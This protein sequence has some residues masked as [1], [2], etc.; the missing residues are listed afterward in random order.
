MP[1][2]AHLGLTKPLNGSAN[3]GDA[4]NA[5]FDA[6]D[7][8]IDSGVHK[9][10]AAAAAQNYSPATAVNPLTQ[11]A[12]AVI[13]ANH[14]KFSDGTDYW[15]A[16]PAYASSGSFIDDTML[17]MMAH[18]SYFTASQVLNIVQKFMANLNG[19]GEIPAIVGTNGTTPTGG[20]YSAWD[21]HHAFASGDGWIQ[22]PNGLYLYWQKTGDTSPYSTYVAAIKT[23]LARLPR[24]AANHLV[25][26][27]AGNEYVAGME[28]MEYM[29]KTGDDANASVWYAVVCQKL[30]AIATAAG[31]TA[32][33]TFFTTEANN[34]IAGIK[35]TLIDPTSGLLKAAT[36]QCSSNLDV[37][38]SSLACFYELLTPA[39]EL[40]IANYFLTN[41]STLVNASG[42]ILQSPTAWE[43][44]GYIPVG[45][46]A[47]YDASPFTATQ[48]QGGYWSFHFPWFAY[49]LAKVSLSKV[50]ELLNTFLNGADP[51]TEYFNQG[52]ST[53]AGTTPNLESPSGAKL[54]MDLFP[55]LVTYSASSAAVTTYGAGPTGGGSGSYPP[56]GTATSPTF[57]GTVTVGT[58]FMAGPALTGAD[59]GTAHNLVAHWA[60]QVL[61]LCNSDPTGTTA[62]NFRNSDGTDVGGNGLGNASF[63]LTHLRNALYFYANK[64]IL[65]AT[66]GTPN[67]GLVI[68]SANNATFS[69]SLSAAKNAG[70]KVVIGPSGFTHSSGGDGNIVLDNANTDTPG[71]VFQYGN[72]LNYGIDSANS[73]AA[74]GCSGQLL[75]FIKQLDD[76]GG[77]L[78]AVMDASGNMGISGSFQASRFT[79]PATA[80]TGSSGG[81]TGWCFSQDGHIS[82]ADGTNWSLKI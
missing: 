78:M 75:R 48:Y 4:V 18:P 3:W 80:P 77:A 1:S 13:A 17:T 49:T 81:F 8:A 32:N 55:S 63:A 14:N 9:T 42:Y 5:N 74:L 25:T 19:N 38:S 46:G 6:I 61:N 43:V 56:A 67:S 7:A 28:F 44:V 50:A 59:G 35:S 21:K 2:T 29:R 20:W 53:P 30:S 73:G 76:T 40:K 69:D 15:S 22:V 37:V 24:N 23:A 58:R 41:Y 52:V 51:G 60:N 57:S 62:I 64:L 66:I 82:Y 71:I 11:V 12:N 65:S 72:N 27:N 45:G 54:T 68:D 47:P 36:G 33:A 70:A 26:V 16:G 79:G 31:D 39:Q 34:V 10:A